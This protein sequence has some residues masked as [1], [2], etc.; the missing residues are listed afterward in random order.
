MTAPTGAHTVT[1]SVY[2]YPDPDSTGGG[3]EMTVRFTGEVSDAS[4]DLCDA[5][6][7]AAAGA[8]V[9]YIQATVPSHQTILPSRSYEGSIAGA[10]WP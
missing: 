3:I 9:A 8:M 7:E 5:A 6:L 4:Q 10:V 2:T 1:Y